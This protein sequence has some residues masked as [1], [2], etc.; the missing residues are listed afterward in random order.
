[1]S[2]LPVLRKALVWGAVFA[3]ALMVIGGVI[4]LMVAGTTGLLSAVIGAAMA[5]IFLAITA[6]SIIVAS[7]RDVLAFFGIVLGSWLAKFIL[8]IVLAVILRDQPFIDPTVLFLTLVV[9][10]VG[11]LVIDVV[12]VTKTRLPY[13]SDIAPVG[14]S[15]PPREGH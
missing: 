3:G 13:D 11:T 7:K 15:A 8:F 12:V 6:A 10:V 4:G 9:G 5:A 2:A 14:A 1:M